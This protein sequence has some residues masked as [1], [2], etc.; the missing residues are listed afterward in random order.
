MEYNVGSI[1]YLID[2]KSR[3]IIPAQVNEQL[4]SKTASGEK[5]SHNI[6]LPNGKLVKLESLNSTF[7]CSLDEVRVYLLGKATEI[8]DKGI[9]RADEVATEHFV[10]QAL[11]PNVLEQALIEPQVIRTDDGAVKITLEDGVVANVRVPPEFLS[12]D[13]SH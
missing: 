7:F 8:I 12:E 4:T 1:V 13:I 10:D 6:E 11:D 5:V 3:A 2:A 9:A